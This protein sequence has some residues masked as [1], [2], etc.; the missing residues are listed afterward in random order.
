MLFDASSRQ[1]ICITTARQSSKRWTGSFSMVSMWQ[2]EPTWRG[3]FGA[4]RARHS[5]SIECTL[6]LLSL[7]NFI[8]GCGRSVAVRQRRAFVTS[9]PLP[10]IFSATRRR[11]ITAPSVTVEHRRAANA[12]KGL[13]SKQTTSEEHIPR[14]VLFGKP[15]NVSSCPRWRRS[16]R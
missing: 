9:P 11:G 5:L 7:F 15:E 6:S 2:R 3:R 8:S 1:R 12:T 4:V 10:S 14:Q 16:P 13:A